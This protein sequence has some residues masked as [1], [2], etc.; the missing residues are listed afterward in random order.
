[1]LEIQRN[2]F[3]GIKESG[4]IHAGTGTELPS[5]QNPPEKVQRTATVAH[6]VCGFPVLNTTRG[7]R[8]RTCGRHGVTGDQVGSFAS[9]VLDRWPFC[10]LSFFPGIHAQVSEVRAFCLN[11]I[12]LLLSISRA[13]VCFVTDL[14]ILNMRGI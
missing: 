11:K 8:K 2:N 13:R 3:C 9:A 6:S 10:K 7:Q 14:F 12:S 4:I 1:M 5:G